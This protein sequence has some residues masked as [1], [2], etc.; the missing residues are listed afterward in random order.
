MVFW[1]VL[2]IYRILKTRATKT[3]SEYQA[4]LVSKLDAQKKYLLNEV[5]LINTVLYWYLLPPFIGQILM[6]IGINYHRDVEWE[7]D[8][9][10]E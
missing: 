4:S 5:K 3:K 1:C 7:N 8:I 9:V 2:L 10:R 6:I